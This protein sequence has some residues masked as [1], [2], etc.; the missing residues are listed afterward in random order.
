MAAALLEMTKLA[1]CLAGFALLHVVVGGFTC[2]QGRMLCKPQSI[3]GIEP[4]RSSGV[5]SSE[6]AASPT[7]GGEA[8]ARAPLDTRVVFGRRAEIIRAYAQA[9]EQATKSAVLAMAM[10]LL[11]ALTDTLTTA[12]VAAEEAVATLAVAPHKE[13]GAVTAGQKVPAPAPAP[14]PDDAE[15][16]RLARL[17]AEL[18]AITRP[19]RANVA[20]EIGRASCRERV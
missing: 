16:T 1:R 9:R 5:Y 19:S 10:A 6:H 3:C 20:Y 14:S 18:D 12:I 7:I 15:P 13:G 8:A 4:C 11:E 2:G 17:K